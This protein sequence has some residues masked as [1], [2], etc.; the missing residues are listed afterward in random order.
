M[1][2]EISKTTEGYTLKDDQTIVTYLKADA[3][4]VSLST[5]S[6]NRVALVIYITLNSLTA[7]YMVEILL[8]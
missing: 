8:G 4:R 6:D 7:A 1:V 3:F 2:T 5:A